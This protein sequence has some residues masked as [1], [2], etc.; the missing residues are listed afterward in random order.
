MEIRSGGRVIGR[1]LG[2]Y[3][4]VEQVG[5]GGMGVVYRARDEKLDRD[6][7]LKVL[8][9]GAI[10]DPQARKRFRREA[11]ALSR[12]SHPHI[13]TI[14]DF[15]TRDDVDF[16]VTEFVAGET[17]AR[18]LARGKLPERVCL[19]LGMQV[20]QALQA[21]HAQGLVHRDL[22]PGNIMV[23]PEG[24][25]KLLDFGL[26]KLLRGEDAAGAA[27]SSTAS[28]DTGHLAGTLPYMA[29]EQLMG[30]VVDHRADL[31]SLGVVLFEMATG[32]V[33]FHHTLPAALAYL[34]V[35]Q[36]PPSPRTIDP[37]LSADFERVILACLE[38]DPIGRIQTAETLVEALRRPDTV[39]LRTPASRRRR[40]M[41]G[42]AAVVVLAAAIALV[43]LPQ[44]ATLAPQRVAVAVFENQTGEPTLDPLG[45]MAADW[46]TQGLV[47]TAMVDVVPSSQIVQSVR[48][49]P[50]RGERRTGDV[51]RLL[52]EETGAALVVIG[53]YYLQGDS[54]RFQARLVDA[55]RGDLLQALDPVAGPRIV[56]LQAVETLR[57][58][59]MA[60][61]ASHM[62]PR[63]SSWA[64]VTSRPPSFEAYQEYVEG[65]ELF[66]Q[67]DWRRAIER[68]YGAAARDSSY[69]YPLLEACLAHLN[70]GETAQIDSI[71]RV[72]SRSADQL[73]P[74]DRQVLEWLRSG[75][76]GDLEGSYRTARQAAELAPGSVW[77]YQRA[78][79][80]LLINRPREVVEVLTRLDPARGSMRGWVPYWNLL[81]DGYHLLGDY[82]TELQAARRARRQYPDLLLTRSCEIRALAA[83]GQIPETD[84]LLEE[85]L[86]L[87]PEPGASPANVLIN[88]AR[89]LRAHGHA[90]A[91]QAALERL[92]AWLRAEAVEDST[93]PQDP[94]TL[95]GTLY[96]A[97][98][99][100]EARAL[101]QRLVLERPGNI[102]VLGFLGASAA[103]L[104][105][106]QA[107]LAASARLDSVADPYLRSSITYWQAEISAVLG[108]RRRAVSLLRRAFREGQ[109][110]AVRTHSDPD[111]ESLR[112]DPDFRKLVGPRR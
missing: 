37:A 19:N 77:A 10:G 70:L 89:E 110:V 86:T 99:Y 38:K 65:Q 14:H 102:H 75:L 23:T 56:P 94:S 34:I 85:C 30:A 112:D 108:D 74:L 48:L 8:P 4:I 42:V 93:R 78:L 24:H 83:L 29:P 2:H 47:R 20:A 39:P 40:R 107:A 1:T 51:V 61:L 97:G 32:D 3:R 109:P 72:V 15:D 35:N 22:K 55:E 63:L 64:G 105:D 36:A 16:L 53:A 54:L 101:Y 46:V 84:R 58:R 27:A 28:G 100:V 26:A 59:V 60:A 68:F 57:Q 17:L 18:R 95:A 52:A 80:A 49:L 41:L 96:H 73:A 13:E 88:A 62:N 103:R 43:L 45:R 67:R 9:A 91:A 76:R 79:Q 31:Y 71:T 11:L 111:F 92:L 66:I 69:T 81:T 25:V 82:R 90:A 5:A 44:R 12:V 33:P 21:A 98:R 6:V 106:R 50:A 104:G 87:P 7:A